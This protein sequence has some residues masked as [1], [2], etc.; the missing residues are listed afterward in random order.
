MQEQ[1]PRRS[2][3]SLLTLSTY[4]HVGNAGA[5]ADDLYGQIFAPCNFA[6]F[7]PSLEVNVENAWSS[8]LPASLQS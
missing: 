2:F 4:I 3:R 8:F 7:P 6:A 5:I 1:L